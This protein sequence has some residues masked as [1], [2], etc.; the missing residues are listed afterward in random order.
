MIVI[1]LWLHQTQT[2]VIIVFKFV[3]CLCTVVVCIVTL[4][5]S[6]HLT[7]LCVFL[8]YFQLHPFLKYNLYPDWREPRPLWGLLSIDTQSVQPACGCNP[9]FTTWFPSDS[10]VSFFYVL[11][12]WSFP[13]TWFIPRLETTKAPLV[14]FEHWFPNQH[15]VVG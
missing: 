13:K 12:R 14:P 9:F 4:L 15:M 8:C 1:C 6:I 5:V 3:F 7:L 2:Y 11:S 10:F